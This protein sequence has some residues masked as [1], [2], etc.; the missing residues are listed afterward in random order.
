MALP[1]LPR[2]LNIEDPKTQNYFIAL[3][4]QIATFAPADAP[5]IIRTADSDLTN[6]QVLGLLS[7]GFAKVTTG[8]GTISTQTSITASDLAN[9]AVTAGSY[10]VNGSAS[11]TVDAQGRLTSASSPVITITGTSNKIDVS[12]GTGTTPTLTI[13]PT[14][15]G[16]TSITTLG[17]I[18]TGTWS[19]TTIATNKGGT[20]VTTLGDLTRVNDTNITLTLGGTPTGALITSTSITAGWS[21][22][23]AVSRGGTGVSSLGDITK[24]DDTNVTLT[25]GGTPTGAVVTSTNFTLGWSGQLAVSRGGTGISSFGTGV[26]T[27]LGTPSSANLASAITDE[28]GT[29]SLVFANTPTLVTPIL[30][31]P[32]SGTL[33]NCTGYTDANV[34]FTDITTNNSSTSKHG[35]LKKLSNTA[36]E[37][38]D[39]TGAWSVPPGSGSGTVNS[40]TAGQLAYYETSTNAVKTFNPP[41]VRAYD[42]GG[43]TCAANGYTKINLA[44]ESFDTNANFTGSTFTPTKA[45][46][47]SVTGIVQISS[48]NLVATNLYFTAI[49]KN[50]SLYSVGSIG[51]ALTAQSAYTSTATDIIDM[52]GSS[53]T[54]EMYFY[55]GNAA[56]TLATANAATSTYFAAS[57]VSL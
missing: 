1:P 17:T 31:T 50:G 45:G 32:T 15:V 34:S 27:W 28:T 20:G 24:V 12:G 7:T 29:G 48:A 11:F 36:T 56:T 8:T 41:S 51:V 22:Q 30:G 18:S 10:T 39:G 40:G 37:Y 54:L 49:Y 46:K 26:A 19:G 9:T 13:S 4:E 6:A 23:L 35:F 44:T 38:M 43:T 55:N 16:Q 14:Y 53:D 5:Y 42:S 3:G 47:Y 2:N 52:N 25:L 33:T 57:W 21:G